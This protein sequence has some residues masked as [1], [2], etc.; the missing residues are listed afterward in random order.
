VCKRAQR[1]AYKVQF[2]LA[3]QH[4]WTL[5]LGHTDL[6][7]AQLNR[8]EVLVGPE[9]LCFKARTQVRNHSVQFARLVPKIR[10][11]AGMASWQGDLAATASRRACIADVETPGST[12]PY[13]QQGGGGGNYWGKY[14]YDAGTWQ[15][16]RREA[17]DFYH[18]DLPYSDKASQ[19]PPWEQEV[20]TAFALAHSDD[21]GWIPWQEC[22]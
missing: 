22:R 15:T 19:A 3:K 21:L 5:Y 18:I 13:T 20:V 11:L 10:Q 2:W 8:R 9:A 12:H 7:C 4:R 17:S 14:Q 6:T 1:H 16:A